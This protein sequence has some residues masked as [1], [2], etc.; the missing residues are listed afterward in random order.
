ML[1]EEEIIIRPSQRFQLCTETTLE[2]VH[3]TENFSLHCLTV[4]MLYA[5]LSSNKLRLSRA[6]RRMASPEM[7]EA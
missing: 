2:R 7:D 5:L 3:Q 4:I 6:T 1:K